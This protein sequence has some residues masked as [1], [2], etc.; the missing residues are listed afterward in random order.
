MKFFCGNADHQNSFLK[1]KDNTSTKAEQTHF[2]LY[3]HCYASMCVQEEGPAALVPAAV[4]LSL[5]PVD[6]AVLRYGASVRVPRAPVSRREEEDGVCG[7]CAVRL[8]HGLHG[9]VSLVDWGVVD[10]PGD[11]WNAR[12]ETRHH[13]QDGRVTRA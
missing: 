2:V 5:G 13:T 9:G 7:V 4:G 10:P 12:V 1:A 8:S 3:H 11:L 6:L